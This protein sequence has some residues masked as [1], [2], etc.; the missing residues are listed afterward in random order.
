MSLP[1]IEPPHNLDALLLGTAEFRFSKGA[2]SVAD[3]A[4]K[5]YRDFGNLKVAT[6][7]TDIQTEDHMGSYRG[8]LRK[9]KRVAKS[10]ELTYKITSDEW[11]TG[12]VVVA[13]GGT[14]TDV[15]TQA[16]S[17]ASPGDT[18]DQLLFTTLYPAHKDVSY[19]LL[20]SETQVYGITEALVFGPAVAAAGANTGD[21]ITQVAH[22]YSNGDRILILGAG[23]AG[24][25]TAGSVYYVV[26]KTTDTYQLALTSGGSAI[27]LTSDSTAMTA[28]KALV[29][30]TDYVIDPEL[31]SI[32]FLSERTGL[33]TV[34]AVFPEIQAGDDLSFRQ[35]IPLNDLVQEGYGELIIYDQDNDERIVMRH[36]SFACSLSCDKIGDANGTSWADLS[37]TILVLPENPGVIQ[38]RNKNDQLV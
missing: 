37:I 16:S 10:S 11:N 32:R 2:T 9:D 21:V 3:A 22:G 27:V 34:K 6:P 7:A 19:P 8:K 29:D 38:T 5:G 12:N 35:I 25:L 24:G 33:I 30:G 20:K 15:V 36:T 1:N 4:V 17:A 31:G 13:F 28:Q 26:G 18:L 23:V 14:I